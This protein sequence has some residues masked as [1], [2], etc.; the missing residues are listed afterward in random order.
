MDEPM[1]SFLRYFLLSIYT[2]IYIYNKGK[3]DPKK[4][5]YVICCVSD[6]W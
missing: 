6:I 3:N 5:D 1:L 4:S 2:Y